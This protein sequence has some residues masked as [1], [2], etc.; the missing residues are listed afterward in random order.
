M[1]GQ[2]YAST[3]GPLFRKEIKDLLEMVRIS[4]CA[5]RSPEDMDYG[6]QKHQTFIADPSCFPVFELPHKTTVFGSG[7]AVSGARNMSMASMLN[8]RGHRRGGS[9]VDQ[10]SSRPGAGEDYRPQ[11]SSALRN[12]VTDSVANLDDAEDRIPVTQVY[13]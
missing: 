5:R 11:K 12:R 1:D 3:A 2:V 10:V 4:Y 13:F 7:S 6:N 9:E 8:V